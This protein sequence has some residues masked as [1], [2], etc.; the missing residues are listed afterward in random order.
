MVRGEAKAHMGLRLGAGDSGNQFARRSR[1]VG[2]SD[3]PAPVGGQCF[4]TASTVPPDKHVILLGAA[5][6]WGRVGSPSRQ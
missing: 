6:R 1:A 3:S 5:T 4:A 2:A